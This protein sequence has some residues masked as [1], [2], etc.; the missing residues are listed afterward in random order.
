MSTLHEYGRCRL[1]QRCHPTA[2]SDFSHL[3]LR[4]MM[5]TD[6]FWSAACN[7]AEGRPLQ[8]LLRAAYLSYSATVRHACAAAYAASAVALVT[9][10][11][12]HVAAAAASPHIASRDL[13][14]CCNTSAR[15][16]CRVLRE[17]FGGR[18]HVLFLV[19][20]G[21]RRSGTHV[22]LVR[23]VQRADALRQLFRGCDLGDQY[24]V[25]REQL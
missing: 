14:C 21:A 15:A 8:T 25:H 1:R 12:V 22:A 11:V 17:R 19:E 4:M 6:S 9:V 3:T 16:D 23:A 13:G 24:V 7:D 5:S 2:D 10:A 18:Y 20:D